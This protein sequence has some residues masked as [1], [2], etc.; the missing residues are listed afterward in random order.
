MNHGQPI[1]LALTPRRHERI[2]GGQFGQ[3]RVDKY[4]RHEN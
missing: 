4:E 3:E 1:P 2:L